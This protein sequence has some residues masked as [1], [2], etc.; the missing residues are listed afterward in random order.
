MGTRAV[1]R[2]ADDY[3]RLLNM[4]NPTAPPMVAYGDEY[5]YSQHKM[6][7]IG[8]KDNEFETIRVDGIDKRDLK[9]DPSL[10]MEPDYP[11]VSRCVKWG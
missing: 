8:L 3:A 1:D 2:E 5:K 9:A 6:D 7:A 11:T 10:F 4:D